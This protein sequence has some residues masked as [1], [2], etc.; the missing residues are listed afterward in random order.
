MY[1]VYPNVVDISE[2][3]AN[4]MRYAAEQVETVTFH[5]VSAYSVLL[6]GLVTAAV[7]MVYVKLRD[8]HRITRLQN[9]IVCRRLAYCLRRVNTQEADSSSTAGASEKAKTEHVARTSTVSNKRAG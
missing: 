6:W 7:G 3:S 2:T 9:L 4:A 8:C 5:T 1:G